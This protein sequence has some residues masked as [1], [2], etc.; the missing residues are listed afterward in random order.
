MIGERTVEQLLQLPQSQPPRRHRRPVGMKDDRAR[1]RRARQ[2]GRQHL[3]EREPEA[4]QLREVA[5][6]STAGSVAIV[7]HRTHDP[8]PAQPP[9]RR[10]R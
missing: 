6:S 10:L 3:S 2:A 4:E 9:L 5:A 7:T 1:D 8:L